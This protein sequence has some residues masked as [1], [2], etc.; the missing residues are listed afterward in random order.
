MCVEFIFLNQTKC[1]ANDLL[2]EIKVNT[3]TLIRM[4]RIG[5]IENDTEKNKYRNVIMKNE[6]FGC[7][8]LFS[9]LSFCRSFVCFS[10]VFRFRGLH[11]ADE[12]TSETKGEK[13]SMN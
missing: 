10:L 4:F 7:S 8:L 9:F 11:V 13:R 1:D 6:T 2:S 12:Q 3:N 5:R